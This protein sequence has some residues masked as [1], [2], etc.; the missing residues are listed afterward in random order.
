MWHS[1]WEG[2]RRLSKVLLVLGLIGGTIGAGA[3]LV[4]Q[5]NSYYH[6]DAIPFIPVVFAMFL[7][8]W[9]IVNLVAWI[10]EGFTQDDRK[11]NA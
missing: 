9:L 8:S 2:V 4:E 1:K 5:Q 10:V 3:L 7:A 6:Q 11:R